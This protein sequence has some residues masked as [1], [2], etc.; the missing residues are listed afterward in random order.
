MILSINQPA[1]LPWLGYYQRIALSDIF[2]L[3][4]HVQFEKNSFINRNKIRTAQGWC[5]LTIPLK[6]KGKFG[7]LNI[8]S[9]EIQ[10]GNWNK[11]HLESIRMNYS[12]AVYFSKYFPELEEIYNREWTLLDPLLV[13]MNVLFM[14]WLGI[15][16]KVIRSS[17]MGILSNKSDLV[18]DICREIKAEV[19]FSGA[20]GKDYL[21]Q[22]SF[23]KEGIKIIFQ[24]YKHPIYS[25]RFPSFEPY[26]TVL[27]LIMN[28]GDSSLGILME[29]NDLS[30]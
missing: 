30:L 11:K 16:T 19:Y 15:K 23:A 29:G 10:T 3:L 20:L 24:N 18:L 17:E 4:D 28:H 13:E 27:D 6:T 2:V 21:E 7:E 22:E 25:Q 8:D 9:I 26:M 5:W 12:K 14:K 1:Y